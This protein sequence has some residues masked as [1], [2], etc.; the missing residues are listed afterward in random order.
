MK[1]QIRAAQQFLIQAQRVDGSW[2]YH[3][4][5]GQGYPEPTCYSLLA[6]A[7][8]DGSVEQKGLEWLNGRVN[9]DGAVV[10][11]GDD[12]PHWS[13]AHLAFTLTHLGVMEA[14][15][16]RTLNALIAWEGAPTSADP[17]G[18]IKL[19]TSL[20]GWPWIG[21]T[22][23]WVEPTSFGL[24]A[25]KKA[26]LREHSRVSQAEAVLYDRVC[27]GGGWN[28]GNPM[29]WETAIEAFL[30][31]TA[32]ALL[33]LQDVPRDENIEKGLAFLRDESNRAYSTLSLSLTIL[34]MQVYTQ[35][36]DN[37]VAL[38]LE[39][40]LSDGSWR[41]MTQLTALS[42]LALQSVSGGVNVFKV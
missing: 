33:A 42:I 7:G 40:Q 41:G 14:L 29:V 16:D 6:L 9:E 39:R 18:A 4:N 15:R 34:C 35:P 12:E 32:I 5:T 26:G 20:I 10:L 19:D 36:T 31:P 22:F 17:Y 24:L 27:V 37:F 3:L 13:T 25:L 1:E 30:P 21:K 23:S 2:P 11:E 38:L 28:V 8:E